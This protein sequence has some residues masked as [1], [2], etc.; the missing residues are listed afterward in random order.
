MNNPKNDESNALFLKE[1]QELMGG[2]CSK[3]E[4]ADIVIELLE[5][6][7]KWINEVEGEPVQLAKMLP[8]L[9]TNSKDISQAVSF[10]SDEVGKYVATLGGVADVQIEDS[11]YLFSVTNKVQ[12]KALNRDDLIRAVERKSNDIKYRVV[13]DSGELI[14]SDDAKSELFKK[15]F[16][17]EPI[18]TELKKLDIQDDE[19]CQKGWS[20]VLTI[21]KGIPSL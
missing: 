2:E 4:S 10:L 17:F 3:I 18:W 16:R 6:I 15:C 7:A 19:Y 14:S 13:H 12:R 8:P 1:L 20:Q 9:K 21:K 5:W 11:K